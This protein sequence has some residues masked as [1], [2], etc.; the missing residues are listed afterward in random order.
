MMVLLTEEEYQKLRNEG[1]KVDIVEQV[2]TAKRAMALSIA[3]KM[4]EHCDQHWIGRDD[5]LTY[6]QRLL[7]ELT[8]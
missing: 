8:E 1:S 7:R 6:L 3:Q 4:T 5:M 2:A